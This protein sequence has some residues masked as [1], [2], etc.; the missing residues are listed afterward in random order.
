[1]RKNIEKHTVLENEVADLV[2]WV[3]AQSLHP[4]EDK[5]RVIK[6]AT[7]PRNNSELRSYLGLVRLGCSSHY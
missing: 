1:V 5:V 2:I 6:E 7:A 4:V 3:D